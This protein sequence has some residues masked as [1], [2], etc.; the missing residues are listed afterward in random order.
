MKLVMAIIHAEDAHAVISHLTQDGFS[1]TKLAT[2][3][4]F[5]KTGNTTIIVGVNED[6]IDEILP[7]LN[8]HSR[9]RKQ[10]IPSTSELG[11]GLSPSVP[12]QISVGGATVFVTDVAGFEKI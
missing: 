12:V 4:G 2:T 5:L 6:K 7:N 1:V 9:S 8:V 11:M 10:M 3:G